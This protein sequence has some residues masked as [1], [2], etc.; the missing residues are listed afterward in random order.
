[1]LQS[2]SELKKERSYPAVKSNALIQ[3]TRFSLSALEYKVFYYTIQQIIPFS[4]YRP[5]TINIT[6]FC[7]VTGIAASGANY[8]NI[9]NAVLGLR[10]KGFWIKIR[11]DSGEYVLDK[12]GKPKEKIFS[13][14]SSAVMSPGE[15][16]IVIEFDP[17]LRGHLYNL[18]QYFTILN[19]LAAYVM[20]SKYSM[21]L[22]EILKSYSNRVKINYTVD[23]LRE[24]M[25]D[26]G[27]KEYPKWGNFHDK[28]VK[29]AVTEINQYSELR[30]TYKLIKKGRSV[31]AVEFAILK[32]DDFLM[33]AT[34]RR[35]LA[36]LDKEIQKDA[37][38]ITF[39]EITARS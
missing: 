16:Q 13:W 29:T 9:K 14:I 7:K 19:P 33:E 21:R 28:V 4:D 18:N 27:S 34:E 36:L 23:K 6:Q 10:N 12:M 24:I 22:Y 17:M 5:V 20:Q 2:L 31:S 32:K 39:D 25:L 11:D 15:G 8:A 35:N 37:A 26:R 30:I 1:M 3:D 38:Q